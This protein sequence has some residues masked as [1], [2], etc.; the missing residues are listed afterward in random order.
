MRRRLNKYKYHLKKVNIEEIIEKRYK[1]LVI[2][3]VLMLSIL[4]VKLFYLQIITEDTYKEKLE[5]LTKKI[6]EGDTA[7]RGRIYDRNGNIIVDNKAV[8]TK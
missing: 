6:V 3:I 2:I 5:T 7:P 1:V 8:K 4:F